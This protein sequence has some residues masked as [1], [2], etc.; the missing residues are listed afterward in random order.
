MKYLI[1]TA[2][3]SVFIGDKYRFYQVSYNP[4]QL[5]QKGLKELQ[6]DGGSYNNLLY[7]L[8]TFLVFASIVYFIVNR[9]IYSS[10]I[11][12]SFSSK[13]GTDANPL[14]LNINL[15]NAWIVKVA[16]AYERTF[17]DHATASLIELSLS[18]SEH[19]DIKKVSYYVIGPLIRIMF[20][21]IIS[22]RICLLSLIAM[23]F[24]LYKKHKSY[25]GNDFM[26]HCSNGHFFY[27]G[28]RVG[29]E[30]ID[31]A[32]NFQKLVPGLA[33]LPFAEVNKTKNSKLLKIL[34][35]YR[36]L[37]SC[38]YRLVSAIEAAGYFPGYVFPNA[39]IQPSELAKECSLLEYSM[40]V[41]ELTLSSHAQQNQSSISE[42]NSN[43]KDINPLVIE[44]NQIALSKSEYFDL[45]SQSLFQSVA[46]C[47]ILEDIQKL[48]PAEV[49]T[50]VLAI[51]AAKVLAYKKVGAQW[52]N[53]TAF[54]SLSARAALHSLPEFATDY[55][56]QRRLIVRHALIYASRK[57]VFGPMRFPAN[58][59]SAPQALRQWIEI[60]ISTPADLKSQIYDIEFFGI[61]WR[62]NKLFSKIF[63]DSF[64]KSRKL[65]E[66]SVIIVEPH[67]VFVSLNFLISVI[68]QV[69][70]R[71]LFQRLAYIEQAIYQNKNAVV[72][73]DTA[74]IIHLPYERFFEPYSELKIKKLAKHHNISEQDIRDW[75]LARHILH[76]YSWLTRQVGHNAVPDSCLVTAKFSGLMTKSNSLSEYQKSGYVVFRK[77]KFSEYLSPS[78]IQ[79][80]SKA[81]DV[82]IDSAQMESEL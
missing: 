41:L 14:L 36:A 55:P 21:V 8:I 27:S 44:Q 71:E 76:S 32:G 4:N 59:A 54:L 80:F 68:K 10:G 52:L 53:Q 77:S 23:A 22:W 18:F 69:I 19:F 28:I 13:L 31:Q 73:K 56:E 60:L 25:S 75:G 48:N 1:Y 2:D 66:N 42:K 72:S 24:Y 70:P 81:L 43:L 64:N 62:V 49:A 47:G 33:I 12:A 16:S 65:D 29:L 46:A 34:T 57:T 63:Q 61:A 30:S 9:D 67:C 37:N 3:R 82:Q 38:N 26:S 45:L 78:Q 79:N 74:F 50:A 7:F 40:R 51:Q 58:L 17:F 5:K 11:Y 39:E 6:G 20:F 15:Y 35:K